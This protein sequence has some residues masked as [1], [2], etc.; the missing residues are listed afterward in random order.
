LKVDSFG[1][2]RGS[3]RFSSEKKKASPPFLSDE[4]AVHEQEKKRAAVEDLV[5][6]EKVEKH[7]EVPVVQNA[8]QQVEVE[9]VAQQKPDN[10]EAAED[11][12]CPDCTRLLSDLKSHTAQDHVVPIVIQ[13][14]AVQAWFECHY[15]TS[16]DD[17]GEDTK[18]VPRKALLAEINR[19]LEHMSWPAWKAQSSMYKDWFLVEVLKVSGAD[20]AKGR[21]WSLYARDGFEGGKNKRLA[22]MMEK[23]RLFLQ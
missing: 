7:V 1:E 5:N 23:I 15:T 21:P 10:V 12:H 2:E 19:F 13:K 14:A 6:V 20:A 18:A 17:V 16:S 8:N 3:A 22:H 11:Q 4:E 9:E